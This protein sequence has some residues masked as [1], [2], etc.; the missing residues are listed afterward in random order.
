MKCDHPACTGVHDNNRYH[1]LCP[2]SRRLKRAK[3]WRYHYTGKG[4]AKRR[5]AYMAALR[6]RIGRDRKRLVALTAALEAIGL[7]AYLGASGD[8][9]N[10]R[11]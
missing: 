10:V 4:Y 9:L 8:R 3:D 6:Q 11:I 5:R 2:R 1:E 7:G